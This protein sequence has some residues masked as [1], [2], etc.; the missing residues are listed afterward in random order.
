MTSLTVFVRVMDSGGFSAAARRL[1]MSTT[2]V[3]SHVQA[4]ED[5]VGA[6]LLNRTTRKVSL[7]E[8]GKAYYERGTQVL[9]DLIYLAWLLTYAQKFLLCSHLVQCHRSVFD[10]VY[11]FTAPGIGRARDPG[12]TQNTIALNFESSSIDP[13]PMTSVHP[14]NR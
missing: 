5:R 9:T 7:T 12:I 4:L 14:R 11:P 2:M 3:S 10:I 1:N 8:V 13:S 6:R